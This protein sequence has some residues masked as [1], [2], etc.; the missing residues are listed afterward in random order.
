VAPYDA[1]FKRRAV[2][3]FDPDPLP[4]DRLEA[5]ARFIASV[6]RLDGSHSRFEIVGGEDV[7]DSS[8]P[9]YV[10]AWCPQDDWEFI[11]VG[12]ALQAVDLHL[13]DQGLGAHWMMMPKPKAAPNQGEVYCVMLAFGGSSVPLRDSEGDFD[14][15]ELERVSGADNEVARAVRVAPSGMNAQ[16]WQLAFEGDSV[17]LTHTPRGKFRLVLAKKSDKISLGIALRHIVETLRHSGRRV[18][19]IGL[20]RAGKRLA[21]DVDSAPA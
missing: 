7:S 19:G 12:Y 11:S 20:D 5:L 2:R 14:R 21:I 4:P 18:T 6:D 8:A 9:H 15:L 1:I 17:R 3:S 10:V 13:A 16:P